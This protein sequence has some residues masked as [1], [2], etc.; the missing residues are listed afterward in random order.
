MTAKQTK[1]V[2]TIFLSCLAI[3]IISILSNFHLFS[4]QTSAYLSTNMKLLFDGPFRDGEELT[5]VRTPKNC[6]RAGETQEGA[7]QRHEP[8]VWSCG[9]CTHRIHHIRCI[10]TNGRSTPLAQIKFMVT[11]LLWNLKLLSYSVYH[12]T[13][14][15][16]VNCIRVRSIASNSN[17][18]GFFGACWCPQG[19]REGGVSGLPLE[20]ASSSVCWSV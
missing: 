12:R 18:R 9:H 6:R 10:A 17:P 15:G 13:P 11:T 14:V 4:V 7:T 5:H 19:V 16:G 1:F 8:S 20:G 3:T 2:V